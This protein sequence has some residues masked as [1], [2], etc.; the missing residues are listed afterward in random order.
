MIEVVKVV[1]CNKANCFSDILFCTLVLLFVLAFAAFFVLFRNQF[2]S[3]K[4]GQALTRL[5]VPST[6]DSDWLK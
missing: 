5:S 2:V 6:D 4:E 3:L 1:G